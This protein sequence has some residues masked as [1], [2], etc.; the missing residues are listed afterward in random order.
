[1]VGRDVPEGDFEPSEAQSAY[2][3]DSGAGLVCDQL[4]GK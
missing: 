3:G 1:M 4:R 2:Y